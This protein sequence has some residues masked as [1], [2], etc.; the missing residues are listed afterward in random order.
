MHRSGESAHCRS[1]AFVVVFGRELLVYR[2]FRR[3]RETQISILY[4]NNKTHPLLV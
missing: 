1:F 3:D 4:T 2:R